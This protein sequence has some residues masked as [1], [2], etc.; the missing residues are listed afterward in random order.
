MSD[1]LM[2]LP[3]GNTSAIRLVRVPDDFESHEAYRHVTGLIAA[4]EEQDPDCELDDILAVLEDHGFEAV[5][6][7]LGPTLP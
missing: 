5:E 2:I 7:I 3:A 4:A 6:F 1:T